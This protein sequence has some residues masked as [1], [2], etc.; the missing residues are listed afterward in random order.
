[1]RSFHRFCAREG[2]LPTDPS[3]EVGAPRVPQGIP[4]ALDEEQ[5]DRVC[6]ARSTGTTP[7]AQRD[8]A[9]LELLY[10]TGIRISE[11][12]G[13]DLGDL[14][15]ERRRLGRA[16]ARQGRTRNGSCRS[17]A[18]ARGGARATY[19]RRRS[20]PRCATLASR[21]ASETDAVFLNARGTPHLAPGVLDDRAAAPVQ[22]VGLDEQLSPHV[23]RHSCATHMLDHGAD[24]RVV[25]ELLGHATISTTQ[26]YTK[27][28]PERLRAVYEAAHPRARAVSA[29]VE[30]VCTGLSRSRARSGVHFGLMAE[31]IACLLAR[32][33]RGRTRPRQRPAL[34]SSASTATSFDEGFAD[35]G[36]VTAERGEVEALAGTLRETLNDIDAALAKFEGGDV[37]VCESCGRPI[38]EARARGDAGRPALHHLRV[39][40]PLKPP[41]FEHRSHHGPL[42]RRARRRGDPARDQPRRRRAVVR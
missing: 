29:P 2:Y 17:D 15:L 8:R 6:S 41:S 35:S 12:V 11:A 30:P 40:A 21:R 27:V 32:P 42:V 18:S 9:L 7:R 16:V 1:M 14:D 13:L 20:A 33:A 24:L 23:L 19:L 37:R 4:K 10:A 25:Q 28:S 38:G 26:V 22:R 31:S 34:R 39:E 3:E 5:V 36:Q